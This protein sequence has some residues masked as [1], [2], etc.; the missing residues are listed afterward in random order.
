MQQNFVKDSSKSSTPNSYSILSMVSIFIEDLSNI[1]IN[2]YQESS[3]ES[4][5]Y[6]ISI[7]D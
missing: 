1:A 4:F 3:L 6:L 7:C 5:C 2:Y